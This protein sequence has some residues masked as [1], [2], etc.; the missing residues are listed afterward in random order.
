MNQLEAPSSKDATAF[1]SDRNKSVLAALDFEDSQDFVDAD[2]GFIA[3]LPEPVIRQGSGRIVYSLTDYGF[4]GAEQAP[5]T[6]NPS[7]WR[8][9]RLNMGHGLFKVTERVYQIRGYDI[10]CRPSAWGSS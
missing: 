7:L 2:R 1:T 9:A 8:I 4:L 5:P 6:V 3:S 10:R